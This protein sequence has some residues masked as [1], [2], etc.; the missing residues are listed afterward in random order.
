[1]YYFD[2][3]LLDF[4]CEKSYKPGL[5]WQDERQSLPRK[6]NSIFDVQKVAC[7]NMITFNTFNSYTSMNSFLIPK[8]IIHTVYLLVKLTSLPWKTA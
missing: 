7:K 2:V 1:M 6:H 4:F 5:P 8:D 3:K